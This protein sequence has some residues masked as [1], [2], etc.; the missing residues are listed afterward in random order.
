M[1]TIGSITEP[2]VTPCML[3]DELIFTEDVLD[4][5]K[6]INQLWT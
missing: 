2:C 5:T 6:D 3:T 1:N 4:E